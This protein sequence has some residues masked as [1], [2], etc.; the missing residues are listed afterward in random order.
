M[1]K[2]IKQPVSSEKIPKK[3]LRESESPYIK[4]IHKL[5]EGKNAVFLLIG[6]ILIITLFVYKDFLS[7]KYLF[8]YKDIGS[9][10]YNMFYPNFIHI[11][12]Y[13]RSEGILKWSF[14][15][16]MGQNIFPG[17]PGVLS[18]PFNLFLY[19]FKPENLAYALAYAQILKILTGGIIFFYY[20]KTLNVN[21]FTS[22]VGALSFSFSGY[23]VAAGGWYTHPTSVVYGAFLLLSFEKLF[24][25]NNWFYFPIAIAFISADAFYL[26][27]YGLFL[28]IYSLL[29]YIDEK[30]FENINKIW[31]LL[32]KM[33]GL[34]LLGIC[35][36]A[37][38]FISPLL[39]MINSPR[40]SGDT[41]YFDILKSQPIFGL[42]DKY[43]FSAIM[44]RAFSSDL[45]GAGVNY[46]GWY[47]YLEA[48]I[49]YA[50]L[51]A[52]LLFPQIFIFLS[53][54]RKIALYA[55]CGLW[56][57]LLL[58]PYFRHMYYAFAGDY[59]KGGF[60]FFIPASILFMSLSALNFIDSQNKINGKIL[61]ITF[62]VLSILLFY[63]YYPSNSNV[64]YKKV[65]YMTFFFLLLYTSLFSFF[66]NKK[67]KSFLQIALIALLCIEAGIFSY[68][69]VNE[70]TPLSDK[71][72]NQKTGFNDY[73][74]DAL[75]SIKTNDRSFYRVNKDYF[76][77]TAI[78]GSLNDAMI[79]DY[80]G[81]PSYQSFNQ[82]NYIK[83]LSETNAINGKEETET[84]WSKG[85]VNRPLLQTLVSTKYSLSKRNENYLAGFGYDIINSFGNVKVYKNK[86]YLPLGFTYETYIAESDFKKLSNF[87]KDIT[88]FQAFVASDDYLK[89]STS[90]LNNFK[91]FNLADTVNSFSFEKYGSYINKLK[92]DTLHIES[93]LQNS[94]KGTINIEKPKILFFSIP[95]DE[96]WH[97]TVNG[98]EQKLERINIGFMGLFL[99]KGQ[100]TIELK[101]ELPYMETSSIISL[102]G[103][104]FYIVM[105]IYRIR[106]RKNHA[107]EISSKT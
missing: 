84:R 95:Y 92:E 105:V 79:Q 52:L 10:S 88:L 31:G 43:Q 54:K 69:S 93:H 86:Y 106:F 29:R 28:F 18:D 75:N 33:A 70:R 87:Q 13:L 58:F 48:P 85:L 82:L 77:G 38:L 23:M 65:K 1:S 103:I 19:I 46:K 94:I 97:A 104:L 2:K 51:P 12:K 102:T 15:Q 64:V 4:T 56:L 25:E 14:N 35:I 68:I 50:S 9:D 34:G 80:Y 107:P 66:I 61:W 16:G 63:P 53:K 8:I 57:F 71:E 41:G 62:I 83:F 45:L 39:Q 55:Y 72:Y 42:V 27:L 89:T 59:Y 74:V 6:L 78:H 26:Y 32:F 36:N 37:I 99:N 24:K 11:S 67:Y 76:S 20:L 30:G 90:A 21:N 60:S 40:V 7:F 17:G 44:L 5:I 73:T 22:I 91:L 96:G 49:F 100:Y 101:Y 3:S 98:K 47:N 81:T